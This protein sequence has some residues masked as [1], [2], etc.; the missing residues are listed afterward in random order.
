MRA[1]VLFLI[2]C[3]GVTG[4]AYY[5]FQNADDTQTLLSDHQNAAKQAQP[6]TV[7]KAA[8]KPMPSQFETVGRA[9]AIASVAVRSRIDGV[10]ETVSVADGQDVKVGDTL[11]TLDTRLLQAGLQQA[12][13]NR[14]KDAAQ[15]EEAKRELA[16][17][18]PLAQ[19]DFATKSA[20]DQQQA[21]VNALDATVNADD[22]AIESMNVQISYAKITAPIDGRIGSISS[23]VGSSIKA[24]D[25]PPLLTINQIRPIYLSFSVPQRFLAE[26]HDGMVKGVL[27]VVA[28]GPDQPD[29]PERGAV[30][31]TDNAVDATTNTLGVWA[32]F[33]NRNT[34][35]WPGLYVNVTLIFGIQQNV[36]VVPA[37]AI[38]AGQN[39][40]F[41]FLVRPDMT[42]EMRPVT[43]D[44]VIGGEAVIT[45]GLKG[46][47]TVVTDG[48][49]RLSDGTKMTIAKGGNGQPA[50]KLAEDRQAAS[51]KPAKAAE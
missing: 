29:M 9:Q 15:L 20:L 28:K 47:E 39:S 48:Q 17:L 46:G 36:I 12:E 49:L 1:W 30:A 26:I 33:D 7:A 34:R 35:L 27:P 21:T 13:A 42:A 44:R 2:V 38:Q 41:V 43:V 31:Y 8:T 14:A 45:E 22:A 5:Y 24:N 6:V 23:K 32:S 4:T 16:R 51:P 10:I 3:V 25:T 19:R 50:E 18:V 40:S 37:E 11:F